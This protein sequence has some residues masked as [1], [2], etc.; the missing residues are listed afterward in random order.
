M[1][2]R[3]PLFALFA[4]AFLGGCSDIFGGEEPAPIVASAPTS[5]IQLAPSAPPQILFEQ[6]PVNF[7]PQ[8][9]IWRAGHWVYSGGNFEWA[10]GHFVPRPHPTAAWI[11]DRWEKHKFGWAFIPGHWK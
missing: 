4:L 5:F 9:Q 11:G 8:R 2:L 3:A 6:K 1:K 7:E 10:A